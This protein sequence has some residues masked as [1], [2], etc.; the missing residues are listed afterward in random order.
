MTLTLS[1]FAPSYRSHH[2]RIDMVPLRPYF[3]VMGKS[4][5]LRLPP[6]LQTKLAKEAVKANRSLNGEIVH[7][8][9]ESLK[10]GKQVPPQAKGQ[11]KA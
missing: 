8:L 7:R 9:A 1:A 5:N 4:F 10:T 11:P 2:A 3:G 6:D